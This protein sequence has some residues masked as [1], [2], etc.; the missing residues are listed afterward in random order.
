MTSAYALKL[1]HFPLATQIGKVGP[2]LTVIIN[3]DNFV[4]N[5]LKITDENN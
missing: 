4:K 1:E 2:K 5:I 3:Y